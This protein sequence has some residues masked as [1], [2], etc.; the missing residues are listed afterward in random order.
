MGRRRRRRVRHEAGGMGQ[1]SGGIRKQD[2]KD[3]ED[4]EDEG[5][6]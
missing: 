3:E 5:G 6:A 4:A 1:K 2:G